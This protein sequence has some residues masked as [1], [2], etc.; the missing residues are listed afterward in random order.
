MDSSPDVLYTMKKSTPRG[1]RH[2]LYLSIV[3]LVLFLMAGV[4]VYSLLDNRSLFTSPPTSVETSDDTV[5]SN[6]TVGEAYGVWATVKE[7]KD[8]E[9]SFTT[10]DGADSKVILDGDL[11]FDL[12]KNATVSS[13][14]VLQ[15]KGVS[16]AQLRVGNRIYLH[17]RVKFE[18]KSSLSASEVVLVDVYPN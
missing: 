3:S 11:I 1:G 4:F 10:L 14:P 13:P 17:L 9:F 2:K 18:E 7:K 16:Y 5:P 12:Y 6:K 15:R 8:R